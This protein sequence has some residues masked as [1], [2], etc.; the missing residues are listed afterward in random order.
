M[1]ALK[2]TFEAAEGLNSN[3][4]GHALPFNE[5][6]GSSRPPFVMKHGNKEI[7]EAYQDY[8]SGKIRNLESLS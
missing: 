8:Q 4:W 2:I 5:T 1:V 3:F 7:K 6:S